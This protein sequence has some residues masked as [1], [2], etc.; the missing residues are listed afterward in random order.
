MLLSTNVLRYWKFPT[1]AM[2]L[3]FI[4]IFGVGWWYLLITITLVLPTFM[5]R[6]NA[7][8]VNLSSNRCSASGLS[9]KTLESS[10]YHN[11]HWFTVQL[12]KISDEIQYLGWLTQAHSCVYTIY[13]IQ[14]FMFDVSTEFWLTLKICPKKIIFNWCLWNPSW[15]LYFINCIFNS[16]SLILYGI[17]FRKN[18]SCARQIFLV[19]NWL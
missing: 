14:W 9:A 16:Q 2:L 13:Q 10:A 11:L 12:R 15:L 17:I 6:L 18:S 5:W 3:P 7:A 19:K 4:F 8:L 1:T